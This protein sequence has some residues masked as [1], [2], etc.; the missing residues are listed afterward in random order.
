M[1]RPHD[2]ATVAEHARAIVAD[3]V[4][5]PQSAEHRV[6]IRRWEHAAEIAAADVRDLAERGED[7]ALAIA[8]RGAIQRRLNELQ[9]EN[10]TC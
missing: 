10:L 2:S 7:A 8:A 9:M 6:R 4:S 1:T 3:C 5:Y